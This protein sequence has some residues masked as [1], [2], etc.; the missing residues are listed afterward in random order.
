MRLS[1]F[2]ALGAVA[3]MFMAAGAT[4]GDASDAG[5]ACNVQRPSQ[6]QAGNV[7]A[8]GNPCGA[9]DAVAVAAAPAKASPSAGRQAAQ[10]PG[11]G[12][13]SDASFFTGLGAFLA[14]KG[15]DA[16]VPARNLDEVLPVSP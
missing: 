6:S 14:T 9:E 1:G 10:P 16:S 12:K 5:A 4:T 8:G 11:L 15:V 2:L 3:G 13:L 7:A